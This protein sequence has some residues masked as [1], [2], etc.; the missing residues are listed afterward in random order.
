MQFFALIMINIAM[1]AIFYLLISLKLERKATEFR[2]KR[3]RRIME[4]MI[5]EFNE[6]AER[7]ISILENRINT[8]RRLLKISGEVSSLDVRLMDDAPS[9]TNRRSK[10]P[11]DS[12]SN[13][14]SEEAH[15]KIIHTASQKQNARELLKVLIHDGADAISK[16]IKNIRNRAHSGAAEAELISGKNDAMDGYQEKAKNKDGVANHAKHAESEYD[17]AAVTGQKEAGKN[18]KLHDN[19]DLAALFSATGDKYALVSDLYARGYSIELISR[20]SG[21]PQGE[22]RLVLNLGMQ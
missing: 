5:N 22:I 1:F 3:M 16:T 13:V 10:T 20:S 7:N 11:M 8:L 15:D 12:H 6:T 18:V 9:E 17:S 2:E 14:F 19:E 21:I 4:E